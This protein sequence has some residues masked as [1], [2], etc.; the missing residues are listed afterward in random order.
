MATSIEPEKYE[1]LE[2]IGNQL[3]FARQVRDCETD[4]SRRPGV[5]W[6]NQEG[7]K[8]IRRSCKLLTQRLRGL[9]AINKYPW[10]ILCR[11]EIQYIR[12]SQKERE[13]LHAEFSILNSLKHPNIVGYYHREHL[14][15]TQELY[16]Y[17]EYCGGGDLSKEILKLRETNQYADE[18]YVWSV[19]SQLVAAL[20]RCHYGIDAPEVGRNAMGPCG[21]LKP[22]GLKGKNQIMILHRDLKPENS[23]L[24][25]P[26]FGHSPT[27]II[28][29]FLG[30]DNSVKLGDFGLSKL[31]QSHDF[32]STYV[33]TPFYMSPEI[34]AAE[35]YTLHSDIWSLGCVMYELCART[36]PFNAKTHFHLIQKIKEGRVDPLPSVYS[37][38]LQNVIKSCLNI[39]P[40]KR[41][42]T[43][44]LLNLPA[45]RLMRKEREVVE[46]GRLLR[47]KEND[48]MRKAQEAEV[49]SLN[50]N[51]EK[52]KMRA[53]LEST[54][55][56][57]W[58]VKA[59]LEIDRQVQ[60]EKEKLHKMFEIEVQSRVEAEV[61]IRLGSQPSSKEGGPPTPPDVHSSVSTSADSDFL[62]STDL[63]S[64]SIDP[65]PVIQSKTPPKKR[66]RTALSRART[67]F[68]SPMDVQMVDPSPMSIA[69][70]SLSPRRTAAANASAI[71]NG[72]NI[73]AAAAAQ[74]HRLA[75]Q[76]SSPRSLI[77]VED[78]EDNLPDLPSPSRPPPSL[79]DPFKAPSRP[80]LLRQ[81]TAPMN[82]L[83][84]YPQ[85]ALFPPAAPDRPSRVPSPPSPKHSGLSPVRKAPP[86]PATSSTE[87]EMFKAVMQ[88]HVFGQNGGGRTLV[89]LA[90][91]RAGGL[92]QAQRVEKAVVEETKKENLRSGGD[93]PLW[94]PERDEMPSPFLVRGGKGLR[95]L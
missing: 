59:R 38:E 44:S 9:T 47:I 65:S 55:R 89:E 71:P 91:A 93:V 17:M 86:K 54:I 1:V 72:K 39:N 77:I 24:Q 92:S 7:Q 6:Y 60:M 36:Q 27:L 50:L 69:C 3:A 22:L 62:S 49:R 85:P 67:E 8:S 53:A 83:S 12:M 45:V 94:D 74:R 58:E 21:A 75:P 16:L 48:A 84:G 70:L 88:R 15:P 32:A 52:E 11:K 40:L 82:R 35:R 20:Y 51:G 31:M 19:F 30:A 66:S 42:D 28:A 87:N 76:A 23:K 34:C 18:E 95:R 56:R 63:S 29:V 13:Q 90:Q 78:E 64:L 57:E 2:T 81:K 25:L 61:Q 10:Q 79:P 43:A 80:G 26:S 68:D 14:K 46:L 73:F 41:P 33:G 5:L 4:R 37:N